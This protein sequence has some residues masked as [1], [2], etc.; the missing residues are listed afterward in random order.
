MTK[1]LVF[2]FGI[3]D[4]E[5]KSFPGDPYYVKWYQML[6]RCYSEAWHKKKPTYKGYQVCEEWRYFS[7]FKAW[8]LTTGSHG[9]LILSHGD[10]KHGLNKAMREGYKVWVVGK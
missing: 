6:R 7:N 8:T 10:T 3:D 2:G 4:R 9:L 5:K 1:K